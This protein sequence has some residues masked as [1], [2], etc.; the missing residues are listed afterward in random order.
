[1]KPALVS[2]ITP[3]F[4]QAA[5]LEA[6]IQSVL[7]QSYPNIE[8]ILIDGGSDDGSLE[9]IKRYQKHFAYWQSQKDEGQT[10]AINQGLNRAKG[11]YQAWINADDI[12]LT[13]AVEEAVKYLDDHADTGLVY[14]QADFINAS[15]K[16][17]G[18]FAAAQTDYKKLLRGYV[19]VPQQA[20][21]WRGDLWNRVGPLDKSFFFAMDYDLWVRIAK[22]SRVTFLARKWAQFRLHGES[23]TMIDDLRGWPEMLKVHKRE[24]GGRWSYI[25]AKYY[26]RRWLAPLLAFRRRRLMRG[27]DE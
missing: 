25:W 26:L 8:Y 19:H 9:I 3:S 27:M 18:Q 16:I 4:N 23:K 12:L 10:D 1:M 7:A 14:G 20:A 5:F 15:G 11:K 22:V 2:I 21:F 17:I 13:N 6:T 24:G